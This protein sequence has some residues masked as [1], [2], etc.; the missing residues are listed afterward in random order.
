MLKIQKHS[1]LR[2]ALSLLTTAGILLVLASAS[3]FAAEPKFQL[4]EARISD[5]QD[6][7]LSKQIT[8]EEVVRLYLN[9]IKAYNGTCVQ[10]PYGILGP[11][12]TIPNAGQLNALST[13]NLRP[14]HRKEFGL[15]DRKARSMTDLVDN[16]PKMPDAL[17][18]AA[19]QDRE[20]AKTGK[21]VGPL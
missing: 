8:T 19:A 17:E 6:A 12:T 4:L 14:K 15:D 11:I 3:T 20:F 9:R 13:L 10:Q 16:D 1:F 7:I 5:I 21:L 2:S 18:V